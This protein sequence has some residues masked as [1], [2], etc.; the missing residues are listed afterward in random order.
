M[1]SDSPDGRANRGGRLTGRLAGLLVLAGLLLWW[2]L[3]QVPLAGAARLL[4]DLPLPGVLAWLAFNALILAA[5]AG[6]WALILRAAGHRPPY[7]AL[8]IYRVAAFGVSYFTP[9]PHFGGEPLQVYLTRRDHG[10][11]GSTAAAAVALDKLFELLANFSFL[12]FGL[13]VA[14]AYGLS[15]ET[16]GRGLLGAAG[17]LFV[18]PL[19]YLLVL[20][21]GRSPLGGLLSRLAPLRKWA[22]A[23][24]GAEAQAAAFMRGPKLTGVLLASVLLW[25]AMI[26]EFALALSLFG[27]RLTWWQVVGLL[28]AARLALLAPTPGAL[29]A[30]EASQVLAVGALGLDPAYGLG[31][32]LLVRGRDAAAGLFGL[33]LAGRLWRRPLRRKSL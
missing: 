4:K 20:R 21:G 15:L 10:V 16:P 18:L 31:L 27:L 26:A 22:P 29:G 24:L 14:A 19:A 7:A 11:P 28:T 1:A 33:A 32:S 2:T 12:A 23:L 6:R 25:A 9:G 30:L 17:G 3:R 5:F 13:G 8:A